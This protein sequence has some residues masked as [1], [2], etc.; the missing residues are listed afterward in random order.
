MGVINSGRGVEVT[1]MAIDVTT[2]IILS[3]IGR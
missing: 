1:A 2:P 3:K